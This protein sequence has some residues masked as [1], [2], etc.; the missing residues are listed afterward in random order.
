MKSFLITIIQIV[1]YFAGI[2]IVIFLAV[3][4]TKMIVGDVD[5][6][7]LE[8]RLQILLLGV[9]LVIGVAITSIVMARIGNSQLVREGWPNPRTGIHGFGVGILVGSCMAGGV[10]GFTWTFGGGSL[11]F[12]NDGLVEY[13]NYVLPLVGFM[14]IA[15]LGEEWIFRGY[16]LSR[17][18]QVM[19]RGW[20]NLL[21]AIL[22]T[23]GH[24]GGSGWNTLTT[25]N[26]F[27]FSLVN[28]A[29]RYTPGGI[30]AAWGFH[31]AWNSIQVL[32]GATL[33]GEDFGVP[34]VH[35]ASEG[36]EWLSGG[37]FGPEGGF[38]TTVVTIIGLLLLRRY[39]RIQ[40]PARQNA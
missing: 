22:F 1:G 36:P 17:L 3:Q 12:N 25:I 38:G 39:L 35:F 7:L 29:I 14:S 9:H 27:L 4:P 40:E 13:L 37:S 16:P 24:W 19:G 21:V 2:L 6:D 5:S 18:S 15:A 10:L 33:T 32:V 11:S 23:A 30:P 8:S 28:G 34:L 20:G 31:F 26:I